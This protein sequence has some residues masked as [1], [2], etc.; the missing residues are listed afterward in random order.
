[1]EEVDIYPQL[2]SHHIYNREEEKRC[3][4][5]NRKYSLKLAI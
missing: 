2:A 3:M 4:E 1:M 5:W